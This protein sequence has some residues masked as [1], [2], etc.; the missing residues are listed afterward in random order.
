MADPDTDPLPQDTGGAPV[1]GALG[2][3]LRVILLA[4]LGNAYLV[5]IL[6][7]LAA[8]LWGLYLAASVLHGIAFKLILLLA[9]FLATVLR[10]LWV[11]I[12][13]PEGTEVRR[14][15]APD[16][17]TLV[18]ELRARL[19]APAFHHVLL[20]DELNAAV[21]QVPRL[22][23]FG[24]PRNYLLIGLPLLKALD[25]DQ[26]KAVLAHE[27]G[28]LARGHGR[29]ANWVYRQRLRWARLL[30]VL[31]Q[32]ESIGVFLF[33]PF[34]R[35]YSPC[36]NAYSFPL[37]R[38]NEYEADATAVRLSSPGAAAQALTA[39]SVANLYLAQRYWPELYRQAD[40][41]P[42]PRFLPF[43]AMGKRLEVDLDG[44]TARSWLHQALE[45]P[46][47]AM[48]T[49]P[50]LG[51]RL[52]AIGE[53]PHLALPTSERAA[54]R[55]LG[56]ARDPI[57]RAFDDR[58]REQITPVWEQ[59]HQKMSEGKARLAEL[60]ARVASGTALDVDDAFEHLSLVESVR[61]NP[62]GSLEML[63]VLAQRAPD[64]ADVCLRL[65]A[66]L[67]DAE[68]EEG[69]RLLLKAMSLDPETTLE[70][71]S[72]LVEHHV[73]NGRLEEAVRWQEK[74]LAREYHERMAA[75][76]RSEL[77]HAGGFLPHGLDRPALERLQAELRAIP[78]VKR[79]WMVRKRVLYLPERPVWVVAVSVAR[80]G[81]GSR[82]ERVKAV[83]ADLHARVDWPG[84]TLIFVVRPFALRLAFEVITMRDSRIF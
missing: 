68:P 45:R 60:D 31:E 72:L 9:I 36:F 20:I 54:D 66:R 24:W 64:R 58:W 84:D 3:Q 49:H 42:E 40:E 55:L 41:V 19:D 39:V 6:I 29:I 57:T 82:R 78:H 11:R 74:M 17:F 7:L 56:D 37:A 48:D 22:G 65:G 8:T 21:V 34:F 53:P 25:T 10:A 70:A 73:W 18:D 16:L 77:S 2:Y 5:V 79:V 14:E 81:G 46:T 4:I 62:E 1:P 43:S 30:T 15:D 80:G 52:A 13:A 69:E 27:F 35:W 12:P 28:H 76:E 33:R 67:I 47:F 38:A 50:S 23:I 83:V 26:F 75:R 51:E 61:R 59:R 44:D 32:S 63:R 71:A